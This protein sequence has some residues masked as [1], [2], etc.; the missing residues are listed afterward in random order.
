[1]KRIALLFL[2]IISCSLS[3]QNLPIEK[4]TEPLAHPRLI[5]DSD[6]IV[7]VRSAVQTNQY[8]AQLDNLVLS[9]A[10]KCLDEPTVTRQKVGKRMLTVSR[11]V[12]ERVLSCS[13]AWMVTC[14]ERYAQRA[15]KEMV[16]AA[17]FEDWNPSHFLDVAEMMTALA[18]GYDWLYY[19]LSQ[20]SRDKI[21]DAIVHHGIFGAESQNQMWFYERA[22]NWNQVCNC[23]MILGALA[24]VEHEPEL[25]I[26]MVKKSLDSN[27][28]AQKVYAPDGV[29]PEGAGYWSYGTWFEV[30]L[31]E[32][33]R[34]ALGSSFGLE[35][36]SGFIE[37]ADFMKFITSPTGRLFNYSDNG[38][39][40]NQCNPL[41]GWFAYQSGDLSTLY[42]DFLATE[43]GK[44]RVLE[45]RLLPVAMFFLARC[46]LDKV[47]PPTDNFYAGQGEQPIFI[48]R[49]G[50]SDKE[51]IY[52]AA[53]GGSASLS[54]GHM[55]AGSFVYEWGGVRWSVDLGSQNY[56]S[57]EKEGIKLWKMDQMSDRWD[58]FRLGCQS[59][60]TLTV[61]GR[62]HLVA[63]RA[64][65]EE[66][67]DEPNCH[68]ARFDISQIFDYLDV[69]QRTITVDDVGKLTILDVV[70]VVQPCTI[71]WTM[72]T[73]AVPQILD[74]G[75]ILLQKNGKRVV[76]KVVNQS[77]HIPFILSNKPT[78]SYD[79]ENPGTCRVGFD[80]FI[81]KKG[82]LMVELIPML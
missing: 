18:L 34:T 63:G 73:E 79:C 14:D 5:I 50:W 57:L 26:E 17:M 39:S 7:K 66:I 15:E 65:M 61:K 81:R 48:Y 28:T 8:M 29:Y 82:Q 11:V 27:V 36:F 72:C 24:I 30:L 55:D 3:A 41:L 56:Y 1:M 80:L 42:N 40:G 37:S 31:I 44:L 64:T 13:Y 78:T 23:G 71:R 9:M 25:A 49:G 47:A 43:R 16:A 59:H 20:S 19:T 51:D 32:G 77:K 68:G 53:K 67:F 45:K 33:L 46:D 6:D 70:Q 35:S 21:V 10:E 52:L 22:N 4:F 75:D 38:A 62:K 76:L 12:M 54:H 58:V 60:S 2:V 69:A 74:N